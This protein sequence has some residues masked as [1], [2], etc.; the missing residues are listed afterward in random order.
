MV[1]IR[2]LYTT[3][4]VRVALCTVQYSTVQYNT[5]LTSHMTL[6][7]PTCELVRLPN[8]RQT[9]NQHVWCT[10]QP[11]VAVQCNSCVWTAE[12]SQFK[13]HALILSQ[14]SQ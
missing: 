2:Y 10:K 12:I 6:S 14:K 8:H 3:M 7:W 1:P 9:E 13:T 11:G 4:E 5:D